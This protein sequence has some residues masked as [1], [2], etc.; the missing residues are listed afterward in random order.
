M[1]FF[2]EPQQSL[3]ASFAVGVMRPEVIGCGSFTPAA[4]VTLSGVDFGR[5]CFGLFILGGCRLRP[6]SQVK[7]NLRREHQPLRELLSGAELQRPMLGLAF[8]GHEWSRRGNR[9]LLQILLPAVGGK[10]QP[11]FTV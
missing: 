9:G 10:G 4:S 11:A 6:H 7:P 5:A 3:G 8:L 2:Y 1:N